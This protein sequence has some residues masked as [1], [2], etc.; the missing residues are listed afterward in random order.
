MLFQCVHPEFEVELFDY[1]EMQAQGELG[2][3]I[4]RLLIDEGL[5]QGAGTV[6]DE[7]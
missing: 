2:L 1:D 5:A 3:P 7:G 4:Y 6:M